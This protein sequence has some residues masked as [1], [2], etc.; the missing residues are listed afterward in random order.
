[1]ITIPIADIKVIIGI[2]RITPSFIG[3]KFCISRDGVVV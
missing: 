2:A 1:M 3:D